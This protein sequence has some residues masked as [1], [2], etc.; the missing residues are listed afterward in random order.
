MTTEYATSPD[1]LDVDVA[2][3]RA[4]ADPGRVGRARRAGERGFEAPGGLAATYDGRASAAENWEERTGLALPAARSGFFTARR[5]RTGRRVPEG[6][7]GLRYLSVVALPDGGYRLYYKATRADGARA[8]HRA[9]RRTAGGRQGGGSAR[10][11]GRRLTGPPAHRKPGSGTVTTWCRPVPVCSVRRHAQQVPQRVDV[12][13][14]GRDA[15]DRHPDRV[16]AV[17][18]RVAEERL[19]GGVDGGEQRAGGAVVGV[20]VAGV[21]TAGTP[22]RARAVPRARSRARPP[23]GRPARRPARRARGCG[24]AGPRARGCAAPSTASAPG[25]G[26]PGRPASRG[27]RPPRP[28]RSRCCAGTPG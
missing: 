9:D 5:R 24:C 26:G 23:P 22:G 19:P 3:H 15:A 13:G 8:A 16:A 18:H 1:G 27:S 4:G 25:S 10:G 12:R 11:P 7:R 14:P 2:G 21:D 28:S 6:L 20:G 17:D